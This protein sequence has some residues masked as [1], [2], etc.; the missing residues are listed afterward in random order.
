MNHKLSNNVYLENIRSVVRQ[1][2]I[3]HKCVTVLTVYRRSAGALFKD[4]V[5]TAL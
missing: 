3:S 2:A 4:P 5:R 1:L